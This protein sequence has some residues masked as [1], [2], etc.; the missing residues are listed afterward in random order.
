MSIAPT[1]HYTPPQQRRILTLA[2]STIEAVLSYRDPALPPLNSDESYL[3][4]KRGCFVTLHHRHRGLRGCIGT[5]ETDEPLGLQ[6]VQ[7]AAAATRDPRFVWNDPVVLAEINDLVIDVS[8]LTPM[9]RAADPLA[10]R[11]GIDGVSIRGQWQGRRVSGCF[12]PQV[13]SE[14]GWNARQTLEYCCSHK[15][16]IP[17]DAWRPGRGLEVY[18]FQ[19]T[20]ITEADHAAT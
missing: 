4:D 8:V 10:M 13:A 18:F 14:Q 19:S 5:F 15:M 11:V 6:I 17:A 3:L 1:A 9:Q 7:M 12:L 20:I 16:N 2:R